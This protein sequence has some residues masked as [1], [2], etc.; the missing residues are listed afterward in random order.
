MGPMRPN[1][2]LPNQ[3]KSNRLNVPCSAVVKSN[4]LSQ[5]PRVPANPEKSNFGESK[6]LLIYDLHEVAIAQLAKLDYSQF[7]ACQLK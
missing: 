1:V 5:D 4:G 6:T 7:D 2:K 3:V